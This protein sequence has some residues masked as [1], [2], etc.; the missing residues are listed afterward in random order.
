MGALSMGKD[1]KALPGFWTGGSA[2]VHLDGFSIR[3]DPYGSSGWNQASVDVCRRFESHPWI[4]TATCRTMVVY[5]V[6]C[7]VLCP[8]ASFEAV[9][10]PVRPTSA[11]SAVIVVFD[12]GFGREPI[13]CSFFNEPAGYANRTHAG[14]LSRDRR[15]AVSYADPPHASWLRQRPLCSLEACIEWCG[16]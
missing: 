5:P 3:V 15:S 11:R 6:Y 9:H 2:V 1:Q 14:V 10:E 7:A 16:P 8:V 12:P 13:S 4:W